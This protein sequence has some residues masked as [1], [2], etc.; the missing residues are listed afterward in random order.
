LRRLEAGE[1]LT[2]GADGLRDHLVLLSGTLQAERRWRQPDG[3]A[4]SVRWRVEVDPR[5][6]GFSLLSAASR[7]IHVEAVTDATLRII[8]SD[9]LD[10]MLE[11]S[12]LGGH[13]LLAQRLTVFHRIP[14]E[15]VEQAFER[16]VEREAAS[17]EA[18]VTQ[19]D[20]GDRYYILLAGEAE[21]WVTDPMTDETTL[22][23]RLRDGDAFGEEALLLDGSRTA[24]VRMTTPGRLLV[25]DKADFD[26][27]LTP[28]MVET[29]DAPS[30]QALLRDGGRLLD[31]RYEMEFEESRIPGAE[32]VPLDRLRHDGVFRLDPQATYVVYCRSGRR[33]RAAAFLLRERGIRAFSLAGGIRDWPYAVDG[34]QP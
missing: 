4:Q 11:L 34:M 31:C 6:P 2:Q 9:A 15:N 14:V 13:A 26:E 8:D 25:L 1:R 20:P 32:L 16:M 19:G 28:A 29:V 3:R 10:R 33:S 24:T 17:G 18:V 5:G 23:N 30:A 7:Q 12:H 22:V 21:V 27:L